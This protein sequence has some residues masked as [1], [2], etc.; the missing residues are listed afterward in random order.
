MRKVNI[1]RRNNSPA[2]NVTSEQEVA[3]SNHAP[4]EP[5]LRLDQVLALLGC[6][7][8][9]LYKRIDDG[10]F[11][12]QHKNGRIAIWPTAAVRQWMADPSNFNSYI[13]AK[14]AAP[15]GI[16]R[17]AVFA[18]SVD[19]MIVAER[20]LEMFVLAMLHRQ[21]EQFCAVNKPSQYDVKAAAA[22]E[23]RL[24]ELEAGAMGNM[25]ILKRW[26]PSART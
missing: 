10:Q 20:S 16:G 1:T 11:P 12:A 26:R 15:R 22:V 4:L 17:S 5:M 19:R 18:S 9:T 8:S 13:A 24:A 14:T 7:R 6:S 23:A 25:P 21:Y 2:T 3:T